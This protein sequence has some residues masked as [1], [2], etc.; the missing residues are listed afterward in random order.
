MFIFLARK[1]VVGKLGES[2]VEELH[3]G[4]I[5]ILGSSSWRVL[6]IKRN[7]VTVED[8]YGKA[9]DHSLLVW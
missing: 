1:T 7:R 4:D 6:G 3:A 5:F 8:V 2:F 9:P